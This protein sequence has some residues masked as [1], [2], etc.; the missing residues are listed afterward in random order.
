MIY[1]AYA[2]VMGKTTASE[3]ML[4]FMCAPRYWP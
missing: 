4:Q 3:T 1:M 2:C